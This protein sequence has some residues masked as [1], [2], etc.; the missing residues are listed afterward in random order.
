M[1]TLVRSVGLEIVT[2]IVSEAAHRE[3]AGISNVAVPAFSFCDEYDPPLPVKPRIAK[4]K[5]T[6]M[7]THPIRTATQKRS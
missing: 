7:A 1:K 2:V 4:S 5:R 3:T 6:A